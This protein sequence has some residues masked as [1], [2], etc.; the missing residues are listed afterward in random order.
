M[1]KMFW[2]LLKQANR[3]LGRGRFGRHVMQM[4]ELNSMANDL[5]RWQV[6]KSIIHGPRIRHCSGE[7][8]ECQSSFLMPD[9]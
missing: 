2:A 4:H 7:R 1:Q 5:G 9:Y 8:L 3:T 6:V